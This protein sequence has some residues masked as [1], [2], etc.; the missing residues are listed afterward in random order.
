MIWDSKKVRDALLTSP[1]RVFFAESADFGCHRKVMNVLSTL[2]KQ[3]EGLQKVKSLAA[4]AL[5][6]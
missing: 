2:F 6:T 4:S 3:L 5:L 1:G